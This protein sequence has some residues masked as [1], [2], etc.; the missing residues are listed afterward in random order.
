MALKKVSALAAVAS[1]LL[2]IAAVG[3]TGAAAAPGNSYL[4]YSKFQVD[5][6]VWADSV[7]NK[8]GNLTAFQL[9]A[10]GYWK[11]FA[12]KSTPTSTLIPGGW[13][14]HCNPTSATTQA[15]SALTIIG[16]AGETVANQELAA[17]PGYYPMAP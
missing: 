6:G 14:L 17:L 13:Y 7:S 8:G 11:P 9:A 3:A 5:P 15:G 16:G 12:Q 2:G 10:L 1:V 4:C